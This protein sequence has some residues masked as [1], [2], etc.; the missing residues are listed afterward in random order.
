MPASTSNGARKAKASTNRP[1]SRK[2]SASS[3]AP[4]SSTAK[5]STSPASRKSRPKPTASS[6]ASTYEYRAV[7]TNEAG[8]VATP[9]PGIHDLRARLGQ[10]HL[11]QRAKSGR[12][13]EGSLLPDCRAYELVSAADQGGYDVESELAA[14]QAQLD[15][16]PDAKDRLLYSMHFGVIPGHRRQ[17]DQPRARPVP[18]GSRRTTAGRTKYVGLPANGMADEGAFGSPLLGADTRPP[19]LR[20]RR[21]RTSAVP[22]SPTARPTSRFAARTETLE[23]GM[24]GSLNPPAD[25]VGEVRKPLSADG[26]HLIFATDQQFESAANSGSSGSTT[27]ISAPTRT[28]LVSTTPAGAPI[29]AAKS[30]ELDV[31]SDGSRILIGEPVGDD[32]AGEHA[33]RPL[34]AHRQ[35]P[36]LDRGRQHRRTA[37]STT[38]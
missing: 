33:L 31:S 26:S 13:T 20:L 38:G 18:R 1:R 32:E 35:Q 37:S 25:P 6:P 23:K 15:A 14:G 34:H 30:A 9:D 24:H 7:V 22:A 29:S 11:R 4:A 8:S 10:R 16:Y 2:R 19:E 12:Q 5:T 3:P 36:E 17:P 28:Q 27:A 21:R